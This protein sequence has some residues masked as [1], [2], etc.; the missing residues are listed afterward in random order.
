M[1]FTSRVMAILLGFSRTMRY[2]EKITLKSFDIKSYLYAILVPHIL[3]WKFQQKRTYHSRHIEC[4][5][6]INSYSAYVT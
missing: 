4:S 3:A 5:R 1:D 2:L 6:T